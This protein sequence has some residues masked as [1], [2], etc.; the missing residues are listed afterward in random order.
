M[1]FYMIIAS[2]FFCSY[3]IFFY[4]VISELDVFC[5]FDPRK[6]KSTKI[7]RQIDTFLIV[8][9]F[10]LRL[11]YSR[12]TMYSKGFRHEG[13]TEGEKNGDVVLKN[14]YGSAVKRWVFCKK[15]VNDLIIPVQGEFGK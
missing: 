5:R 6:D 9:F 13:N 7:E 15:K 1:L 3:S 4:L 11:H 10:C 8:L 12:T 14:I 2:L